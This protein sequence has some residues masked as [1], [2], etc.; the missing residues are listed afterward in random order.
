LIDQLD[1]A[2]KSGDADDRYAVLQF[3][4]ETKD[5][6]RFPLVLEALHDAA[7]GSEAMAVACALVLQG[8]DLGPT[9]RAE[10][11]SFQQREPEWSEFAVAALRSHGAKRRPGPPEAK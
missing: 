10:F 3:V 4:Y 6:S 5:V 11:E 7:L 2:W 9:A 1:V 8:Y